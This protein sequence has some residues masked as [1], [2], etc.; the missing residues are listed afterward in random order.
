MAL[1]EKVILCL[2]L[3]AAAIFI[4]G[5]AGYIQPEKGAVANKE[6]RILFQESGVKNGEWQTN[7]LSMTYSLHTTAD[8]VTLSGKLTVDRSL[9][10]SFGTV[11]RFYLTMN[12]IDHQGVVLD[13]V[14][15]TPVYSRF[16]LMPDEV[17]IEK[18]HGKPEGSAG[19]VFS[20]YGEFRGNDPSA[21]GSW[22]ISLFPFK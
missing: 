4:A 15:I 20:Y 22:N 11:M 10:D 1:K 8:T 19:I 2:A 6:A 13:T 17:M 9:K 18:V 14:D 21:T 16:S 12:I 7:D 5:C 3:V